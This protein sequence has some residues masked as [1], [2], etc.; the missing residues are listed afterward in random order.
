MWQERCC[1][2]CTDIVYDRLKQRWNE[3]D[4]DHE[5][6]GEK[7]TG[8]ENQSGT[9]F[10]DTLV[11]EADMELS[12]IIGKTVYSYMKENELD[13]LFHMCM[14][15]R[16]AWIPE[17][18]QSLKM[19]RLDRYRLE[20]NQANDKLINHWL[21]EIPSKNPGLNLEFTHSIP[22]HLVEEY[23][24]MFTGFLHDMPQMVAHK[25]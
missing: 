19:N 7:N 15:N 2:S 9:I 25:L 8:T 12:E 16:L 13:C 21:E 5:Q 1:A 6:S 11:N 17:S 22:D 3:H 23:V 4:H 20:N 18:W 10:I 24:R 14:N